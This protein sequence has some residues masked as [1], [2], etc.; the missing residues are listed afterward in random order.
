V[1]FR[2]GLSQRFPSLT[3]VEGLQSPNSE[4]VLV[5]P[6]QTETKALEYYPNLFRPD[7]TPYYSLVRQLWMEGFREFEFYSLGGSKRV[8]IPYLLDHFT[9]L[10]RGKRCFVVGN[11]PSLNRIDMTLLKDE[12]TLGSNRC[13]LGFENWGFPFSYWGVGDWLQMEEYGPEYERNLPSEIPKFFS[14]EYL[15]LLHFDNSCPLNLDN[16]FVVE[17]RFSASA[18]CLYLGSTVTY[19]LLQ[20][21]ATMGCDPI[22]LIGVD[23]R[24]E[25]KK[26]VNDSLSPFQVWKVGARKTVFQSI[27]GTAIHRFLR[28]YREV[29]KQM[30][31]ER[32]ESLERTDFWVASDAT[33]PTHFDPRYVSGEAK[34]FSMPSPEI[35][36]KQFD[37][38]H[39]W[40]TDNDRKILNATPG[41]ALES[42]P[43]IDFESLF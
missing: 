24:F 3:W 11:G 17:P 1:E 25:F 26:G 41:T 28:T 13:Y 19:L 9:D 6:V 22:I 30:K 43:K 20:I 36:E 37:C 8:S 32:G 39:R 12:I 7:W 14:M 2:E 42:F 15:P 27:E 21:A 10:H 18:D 29:K 35:S 5:L 38:A 4:T 23:H 33:N 16:R 31:K 34:R 40:A